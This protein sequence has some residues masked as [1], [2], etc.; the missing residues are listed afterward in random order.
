MPMSDFMFQALYQGV[1]TA[2]ISLALYGRAIHLSGASNAAA[3]PWRSAHNRQWSYTLHLPKHSTSIVSRL[4]T[5]S[6]CG[7]EILIGV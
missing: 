5:L 1:L 6:G 3:K 7:G 4:P 2:A